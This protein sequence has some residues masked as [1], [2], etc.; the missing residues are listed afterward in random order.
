MLELAAAVAG[1]LL[2]DTLAEL[3][4]RIRQ[5]TVRV[6]G[7]RSGDGS[8]VIWRP[9]GHIVTNAHVAH[10]VAT[11][12]LP[13]GRAFETEVR[14][15]DPERDLAMIK[16]DAG[17]LPA[18]AIGDA[19]SLRP[20]DLVFASGHPFGGARALTAGIVHAVRSRGG[21]RGSP[22]VE[23]DV[24]VE[25]GD[26]GGP[27]VDACGRVVGVTAMVA[28]GL[29]LAIPSDIVERF[30]GGAYTGARLGVTVCPVVGPRGDP[31][32][33]GFVV[34]EVAPQS[35]AAQAGLVMGDVLIAVDDEVFRRPD[36][37]LRA[38]ETTSRAN[39][40]RL[41]FTRGGARRVRTVLLGRGPHRATLP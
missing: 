33:V 19:G 3:A 40:L 21:S 14:G 34:L 15:W 10:R 36:D 17:L 31:P 30:L 24:R 39:G 9:D 16:V 35:P 20:G 5:I 41:E 28:G 11:V 22:W 37:L 13:D 4:E 32:N 38:V 26:S 2:P 27:L 12:V 1:F 18:A 8:G 25:P 29:A 23:A 6:R 7:R